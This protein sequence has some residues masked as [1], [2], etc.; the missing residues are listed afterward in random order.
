MALRVIGAGIGRTGTN[1]LKVALEMLLGGPCYHMFELLRKLDD[2][3]AWDAAAD[4]LPVDWHA[5]MAGWVA[6]VDWPVSA[7]WPELSIAFPDA[8][9]LLSMRDSEAWWT[10]ASATINQDVPKE[11]NDA[12]FAM[13]KKTLASRFTPDLQDKEA[14]IAAYQ[15]HNAKVMQTVPPDRLIV[16]R[17]GDGWEPICGSLGLPIPEEPFPLTNTTAEFLERS[18]R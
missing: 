16:W 18:G 13:V 9:I 11:A 6:G 1:S 15:A 3:P 2:V 7:F 4:G 17:P 5:L 14:C 10:S 8:K 12:W